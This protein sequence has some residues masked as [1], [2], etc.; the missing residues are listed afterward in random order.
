MVEGSSVL[1]AVCASGRGG[2]LG[3]VF[4]SSRRDGNE[5]VLRGSGADRTDTTSRKDD[6]ED[7]NRKSIFDDPTEFLSIFDDPTELMSFREIS[8]RRGYAFSPEGS[9]GSC[10][11]FFLDELV[12][13]IY[14]LSKNGIVIFENLFLEDYRNNYWLQYGLIKQ[15]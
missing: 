9:S 5:Q 15:P 14:K 3:T 13:C 11:M 7:K 2:W 4:S 10:D 12:S 1:P 6:R 8:E